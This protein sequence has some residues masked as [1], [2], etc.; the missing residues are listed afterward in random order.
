MDEKELKESK[1]LIL[2]KIEVEDGERKFTHDNVQSGR[3][4]V[5][6][7]TKEHCRI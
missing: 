7:Q 4:D 5:F 1:E 3:L 6:A 2:H